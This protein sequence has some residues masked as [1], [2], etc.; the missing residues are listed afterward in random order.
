M[1]PKKYLIT[2]VGPTA[3]GKTALAIQL[4]QH[5]QTEIISADSRQFFKEMRIGTAVPS[6]DELKAAPHHFIQHKSIHEAYTV[7]QFEKEA[8]ELLDRLFQRHQVLILVGGSGLY[9]DAVL[10][11]LNHFPKVPATVREEVR[12]LYKE[13]G[14]SEI[15]AQ[16]LQL[17]PASED[18]VD[19]LNPQRVLRALEVCMATEQPFS[20]FKNKPKAERPFTAIQIG[21]QAE[22]S[23]IYDR[24]NKRVDL[25]VEEGLEAEARALHPH[26]KLNALVT[27]GYR[28]L[29]A[30]FD[31]VYNFA[32]AIEEIKKNTRRFAKRQLTWYRKNEQIHWFPFQTPLAAVLEHIQKKMS[33]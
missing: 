4:A 26:R 22:R 33:R 13:K 18:S 11:G 24:I 20:S 3:I 5:F 1:K 25:M 27:V 23:V 28:E 15:Q 32:K 21:L 17:D 14:L 19:M 30:Y 29:F 31:G 2:V 10:N 8:L 16:L 9:V 12:R 6:Q 7:G